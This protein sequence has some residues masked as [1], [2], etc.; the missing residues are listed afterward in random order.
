MND[1][2][3]CDPWA[4]DWPEQLQACHARHAATAFLL[5]DCGFNPAQGQHWLAHPE[6]GFTAL[7]DGTGLAGAEE[8]GMFL[9]NTLISDDKAE[10]QET[11]GRA[12]GLPM[13]SWIWSHA[14]K[15]ALAAHLRAY[16][17]VETSDG[18]AW[19]LRFG[20][21]RCIPDIFTAL[22]QTSTSF[23][24]GFIA[25]SFFDRAGQLMELKGTQAQAN[26]EAA[27]LAQPLAIGDKSFAN[28]VA[29]GEPDEALMQLLELEP[30]LMRLAPAS[31]IHARLQALIRQE[32]M[33]DA[34]LIDRLRRWRVA[35]EPQV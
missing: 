11:V 33:R 23:K 26:H 29:S 12:D 34:A 17:E 10:L 16:V 24:R 15:Q 28:L 2:H 5:V 18:L 8:L 14:D 20:D 32:P 6:E 22:E 7:Y 25:W 3:A 21:T 9:G 13:L 31:V 1:L 35:L 30:S 4:C 19:P 27:T